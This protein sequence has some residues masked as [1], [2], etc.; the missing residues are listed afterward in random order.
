MATS[1]PGIIAWPVIGF[2]AAVPAG[3][4]LLCATRPSTGY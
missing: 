4:W 2:V 1:I 3:R